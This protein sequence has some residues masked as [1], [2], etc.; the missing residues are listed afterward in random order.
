MSTNNEKKEINRREALKK[1]A[2]IGLAGFIASVV[3]NQMFGDE[4]S[5]SKV[6]PRGYGSIYTSYRAYE[7]Y[8]NRYYCYG[9]FA[10]HS[11]YVSYASYSSYYSSYYYNNYSNQYYSNYA[12]QYYSNYAN[13]YDNYS[14]SLIHI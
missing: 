11:Y 2:K 6:P 1:M 9:S 13:Q 12:N 8:G 14:L 4:M 5:N 7:N 10:Y 3:P